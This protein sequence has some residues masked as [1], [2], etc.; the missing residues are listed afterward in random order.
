M[1]P[2]GWVN[3][4]GYWRF[5]DE[6]G[7]EFRVRACDVRKAALR[8]CSAPRFCSLTCR[9]LS[10]VGEGNPKWRGGLTTMPDGYVYE[11][12]PDHPN[13]TQHGYVLEHRL[14]VEREIGRYLDPVE[15][16]HHIDHVR[17]NNDVDNL[18]LLPSQSEHQTRHGYWRDQP[19]GRC[20][21]PCR[22]SAAH[23]R[24]H[25]RAFCSLNCIALFNLEIIN[26]GRVSS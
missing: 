4:N 5:C 10:Y 21:A 19:C 12:A 9:N 13:A 3:P 11:Y 2:K 17:D 15:V 8:G 6:C 24:R 25:A 14:V 7:T 18:E 20:G 16:V 22:R 26:A 1:P 23:R